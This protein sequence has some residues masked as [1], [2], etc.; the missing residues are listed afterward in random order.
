M[1]H[2]YLGLDLSTQQLKCTLIDEKHDIVWEKAVN[3]DKDLPEFKTKHGA[4]VNDNVVTS[5]T[6]MWVKAMDLLLQALKD[7]SYI[8]SIRGISGAGQVKGYRRLCTFQPLTLPH[9]N[10]E[11][12]T[13]TSRALRSCLNWMIKALLLIN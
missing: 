13:G 10:M 7:T 4:I 3:F 8:G 12:C 2:Y 9:S 11:V 6:L 5:P 1:E